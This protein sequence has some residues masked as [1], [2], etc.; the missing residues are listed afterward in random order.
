MRASGNHTN[1]QN[2]LGPTIWYF[3]VAVSC[4]ICGFTESGRYTSTVDWFIFAIC[5]RS[6]AAYLPI[7]TRCW[8]L[9]SYPSIA[10]FID[11]DKRQLTLR[12][13][14]SIVL[15]HLFSSP[16]NHKKMRCRFLPITS[17][18]FSGWLLSFHLIH[19]GTGVWKDR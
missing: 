1:V 19:S 17:A 14:Y 3:H 12:Y 8:L 9:A 6:S 13:L 15:P 10:S 18:S 11:Q 5:R 16:L 7:P 4:G 2:G